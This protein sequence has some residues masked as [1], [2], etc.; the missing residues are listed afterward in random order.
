MC[1]WDGTGGGSTAARRGEGG[2]EVDGA[3]GLGR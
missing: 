3:R 1:G 2:V